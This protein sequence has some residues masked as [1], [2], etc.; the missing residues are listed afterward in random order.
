[1]TGFEALVRWDHPERGPIS[2]AEFIPLAE[3]I[4]L[5]NEIGE[6]V[7]ADGLRGGGEMAAANPVAVN[8]SPVQFRLPRCRRRPDR[9]GRLRL[10]GQAA[11]A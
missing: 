10:P 1:M 4:G 8:L 11:R 7:L 6:W 3:E 9:A 5:I 2:P